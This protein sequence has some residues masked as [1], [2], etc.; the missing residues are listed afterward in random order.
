MIYSI[1]LYC[2]CC[3]ESARPE[4][5]VQSLALYWCYLHDQDQG[6]TVLSSVL[7]LVNL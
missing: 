3:N 5:Q 1:L 4:I 7:V 2:A 6:T